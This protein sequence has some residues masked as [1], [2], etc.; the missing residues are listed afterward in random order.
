MKGK[1]KILKV[2]N[3]SKGKRIKWWNILKWTG[4]LFSGKLK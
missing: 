3:I 1:D 4:K 2:K